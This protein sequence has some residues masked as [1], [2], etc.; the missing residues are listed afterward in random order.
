MNKESQELELV[1]CIKCA[2][3]DSTHQRGWGA[4]RLDGDTKETLKYRECSYFKKESK[5]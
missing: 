4:C 5:K 1:Q 2:R 3:W